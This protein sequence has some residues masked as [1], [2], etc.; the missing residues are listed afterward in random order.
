MESALTF[1]SLA[2]VKSAIAHA[3]LGT[4][5]ATVTL[6]SVTLRPHQRDAVARIRHTLDRER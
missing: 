6:G 4:D 2:A 3:W 5:T 1:A